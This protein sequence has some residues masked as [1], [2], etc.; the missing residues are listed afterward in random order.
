VYST[1]QAVSG[2]GLGGIQ[3]LESGIE[4]YVCNSKYTLQKFPYE[5]FNNCIPQI[6]DFTDDRYTKEEHKIVSLLGLLILIVCAML[7]LYSH[8]NSHIPFDVYT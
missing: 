2:A 6:D 5:I 8:L 1:Y 4:H 3:D 7:V